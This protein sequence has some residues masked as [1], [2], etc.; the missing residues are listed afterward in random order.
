MLKIAAVV[1]IQYQTHK[2]CAYRVL[3]KHFTL[4]RCLPSVSPRFCLASIIGLELFACGRRYT[5]QMK[6]NRRWPEFSKLMQFLHNLRVHKDNTYT[7]YLAVNDTHIQ[8]NG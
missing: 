7:L 4:T 8:T 5:F 3:C 2:E 6:V 1:G